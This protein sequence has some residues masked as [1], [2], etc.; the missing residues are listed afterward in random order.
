MC[1]SKAM[2]SPFCGILSDQITAIV[3]N[4]P[5][6][7][8]VTSSLADGKPEMQIKVDRQ[9]AATFGL[10]PMQVAAEIK[11][12]MQGTV[13]TRYRVEGTEVDVRVRYV[14]QNHQDLEY[15]Q[16]LTLRNSSGAVVKLSQIAS[17][18]LTQGPIQINR[19]DQ[20]RMWILVPIYSI[21]ICRAS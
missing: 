3:R 17:F 21:G 4:V 1:R 5:G 8:E 15:L 14:P 10:T 11:N 19:V 6:T 7:R 16:N 12:A 13:A 9:R 2:T 20:V 18:E